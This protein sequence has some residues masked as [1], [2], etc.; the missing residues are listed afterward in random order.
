MFEK[1]YYPVLEMSVYAAKNIVN[2]FNW[3]FKNI[4]STNFNDIFPFYIFF[5]NKLHLYEKLR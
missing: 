5:D 2:V 1:L 4:T 3:K